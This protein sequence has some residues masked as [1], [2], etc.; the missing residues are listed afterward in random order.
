MANVSVNRTDFLWNGERKRFIQLGTVMTEEAYRNRGY[1]RQLMEQIE[2][3]YRQN[4]DGMYLF[5]NNSVLTFYPKFGFCEAKEYHYTRVVSTTE[6]RSAEQIL[7]QD[8][9]DYNRFANAIENSVP[10]SRFAL[11]GNSGLILFY[12]TGF[13]HENIYYIQKYDTYVIAEIEG[14]SLFL[15]NIFSPEK[16]LLDTVIAAFGREIKKVTLGF[17]PLDTQGYTICVHKEEDCTL[18]IK[19]YGFAGFEQERIMVPTLA[20]A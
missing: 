8:K 4:C 13:M 15:H 3:E 17:T 18:F 1:I 16:N 6:D 9:T 7:L 5:A 11:M 19:G 12:A 10:C 20:H 2:T 14:D